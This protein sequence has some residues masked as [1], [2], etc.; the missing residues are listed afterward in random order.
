MTK[1]TISVIVVGGC[2]RSA[3]P[4]PGVSVTWCP[5]SRYGG[6]ARFRSVLDTVRSGA[7]A[8]VVVLVRWLGHSEFHALVDTCRAAK[9]R[10]IVVPGGISSALQAVRTLAGTGGRRGC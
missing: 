9:T 5:S 2:K 10:L 3:S 1:R 8:A 4:L 7:H 6:C